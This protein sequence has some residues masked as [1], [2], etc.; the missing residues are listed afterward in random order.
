MKYEINEEKYIEH[1]VRL[2]VHD[3]RFVIFEETIKKIDRKMNATFV[4]IVT[5]VV[6]PIILKKLGWL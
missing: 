6:I 2:R 5:G 4:V 3:A 1:E